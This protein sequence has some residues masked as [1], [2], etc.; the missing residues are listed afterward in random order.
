ME[1]E[2]IIKKNLKKYKASISSESPKCK[3]TMVISAESMDKA[4]TRLGE[5]LR[6]KYIDKRII[7]S[8]AQIWEASNPTDV[9]KYAIGWFEAL[10][11]KPVK[12]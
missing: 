9:V 2:I 11:I 7:I 1:D 8:S 4:K 6:D 5:I 12:S 3:V 10:K